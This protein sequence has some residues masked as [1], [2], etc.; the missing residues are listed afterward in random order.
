MKTN[1]LVGVDTHKDT[2][3]CFVNGRFKEFKSTPQGFKQAI[4]WA[5]S[6]IWVIEGAY[7]FGLAFSRFLL[8]C[9]CEVY[10]INPLLTKTLRTALK[11]S[12]PKSDYGDAKVISLFANIDN[13]QK[14]S[15]QTIKL[16]EKLSARKAL[17]KQK[18]QITNYLNMLFLTRGEPLPFKNLTSK[19]AL[20]WLNNQK[21]III[22]TNAQ[23]LEKILLGIKN[24]ENEIENEMPPIAKALT[25]LE[26][27]STITACTIY[28]ETKGK[29][30]TKEK[31]ASY[32]GVSPVDCSSGKTSRKR[33][34]KG[35]NRILNS[36]FY[37]LS[38]A[39]KRYNL[40][41]KAYYEKKLKEGKSPRHA[42]KCLA[43]QL[44]NIVFKI[45]KNNSAPG[46][47]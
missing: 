43:R 23:I 38:I 7:C 35:G 19:K 40:K 24:L 45:L 39:Q 11:V 15:L 46:E 4:K 27:I 44:T 14:V 10:D 18:T 5:G 6:S 32:C 22:Q 20:V 9:G 47:P 12:T 29:I 33:N 26:G 28:T 13:M 31:F 8:D 42:R 3:A 41:A 34:N 25:S 37:S 17:V 16:K 36:I 1:Q 21:D 2:L 30:T